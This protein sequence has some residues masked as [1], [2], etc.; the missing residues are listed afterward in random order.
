MNFPFVIL[1]LCHVNRLFASSMGDESTLNQDAM[2]STEL[3]IADFDHN[4]PPSILIVTLFRNKAHTMPLFFTYLNRI[5]YPRDRI[6]LWYVQFVWI[7]TISC[8]VRQKK[9]L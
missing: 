7:M 2:E 8:S 3:P 9:S 6:S 4:K 1:I 5:E